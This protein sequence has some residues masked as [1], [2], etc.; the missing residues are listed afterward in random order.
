MFSLD[1]A[2]KKQHILTYELQIRVIE[3]SYSCLLDQSPWSP[4]GRHLVA[5]VAIERVTR[6]AKDK[7]RFIKCW[8]VL[9]LT[10]C[11]KNDGLLF[12]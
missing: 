6:K 3:V 9:S 11:C 7:P 5:M 8:E 4:S 10:C 2:D 12:L 1:A